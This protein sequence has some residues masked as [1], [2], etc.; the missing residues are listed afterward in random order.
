MKLHA[1]GTQSPTLCGT[2]APRTQIV[3]D[4]DLVTCQWCRALIG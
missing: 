2:D 1:A 4:D 3:T